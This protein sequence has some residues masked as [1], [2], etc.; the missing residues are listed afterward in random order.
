MLNSL[1][2]CF[3]FLKIVR[4][5]WIYFYQQNEFLTTN[6]KYFYLFFLFLKKQLLIKIFCNSLLLHNVFNIFLY[7]LHYCRRGRGKTSYQ[8]NR[9][10]RLSFS[11]LNKYRYHFKD[12][13]HLFSR[14]VD[15]IF[16]RIRQRNTNVKRWYIPYFGIK[17]F[18]FYWI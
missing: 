8:Q 7:L 14:T 10:P 13:L 11:F 1:F 16:I 17:I 5:N 4:E 15:F 3:N 12:T 9:W 2:F 6:K 18:Y